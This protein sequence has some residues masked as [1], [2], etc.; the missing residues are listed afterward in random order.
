MR[1]NQE[2]NNL[3]KESGQLNTKLENGKCI[4]LVHKDD[5]VVPFEIEIVDCLGKRQAVCR[6]NVPKMAPG[7]NPT[8]FPCI[9]ND[10][11]RKKRESTEDEICADDPDTNKSEIGK[12]VVHWDLSRIIML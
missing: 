1:K 11:S 7:G 3:L 9:V 10:H 2:F 6:K 12:N 4:S 5:L 8:T